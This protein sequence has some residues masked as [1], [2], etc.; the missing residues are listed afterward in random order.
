M[1]PLVV[2]G[3]RLLDRALIGLMVY[4]FAQIDHPDQ[5]IG[6]PYC[7]PPFVQSALRP[8]LIFSGEPS[9][10][11]ALEDFAVVAHVLDDPHHPVVGQAERLRRISPPCRGDV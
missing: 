2:L 4:T 8:R 5:R 10:I 11:V 9:P 6:M 3:L 1:K 7:R